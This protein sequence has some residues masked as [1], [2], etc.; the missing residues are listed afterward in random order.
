MKKILL[1]LTV[2]AVTISGCA[3]PFAPVPGTY[4]LSYEDGIVG[5]SLIYTGTPDSILV[6]GYYPWFSRIVDFAAGD[7]QLDEGLTLED[8]H[9]AKAALGNAGNSLAFVLGR[10]GQNG[11]IN[12]YID[13]NYNEILETSEKEYS[14]AMENNLPSNRYLMVD[15]QLHGELQRNKLALCYKIFSG[16]GGYRIKIAVVSIFKGEMN[17]ENGER[18]RFVVVDANAN[19]VFND[20]G[21]DLMAIDLDDDGEINLNRES[22]AYR[23]EVTGKSKTY[24]ISMESWPED[25]TIED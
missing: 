17:F 9:V 6:Y 8:V 23:Q 18:R 16:S 12:L 10:A 24:K 19:G 21:Q 13:A 5:Q 20:E 25:I 2:L 14:F 1:G 3:V 7:Y 4:Q 11:K 15:Y 22:M